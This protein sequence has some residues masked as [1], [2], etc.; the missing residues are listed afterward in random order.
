[1]PWQKLHLKAHPVSFVLHPENDVAKMN[2]QFISLISVYLDRV[3]ETLARRC[4]IQGN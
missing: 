1:M 4:T 3:Q 2:M